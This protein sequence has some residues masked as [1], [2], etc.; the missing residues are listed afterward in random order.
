MEATKQDTLISKFT[1]ELKDIKYLYYTSFNGALFTCM[2]N[3]NISWASLN[4][5]IIDAFKFSIC[6]V[7]HGGC[8]P[9]F[10]NEEAYRKWENFSMESYALVTEQILREATAAKSYWHT[11]PDK[12][13]LHSNYLSPFKDKNKMYHVLIDRS[14]GEAFDKQLLL[15]KT[16]AEYGL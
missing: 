14:Y 2:Y 4:N 9:E 7:F 16:A 15:D 5:D 12:V 13:T 8:D 1:N 10:D 3:S 6:E 11:S